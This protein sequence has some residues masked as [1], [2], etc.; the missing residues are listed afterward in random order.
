MCGN[1]NNYKKISVCLIK[2]FFQRKALAQVSFLNEM[3]YLFFFIFFY[4]IFFFQEFR[5][6]RDKLVS[7]LEAILKKKDAEIR[8]YKEQ[9]KQLKEKEEQFTQVSNT[10]KFHY[11]E[12]LK[13]RHFVN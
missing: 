9:I 6:E 1:E 5:E 4:F 7:G 12:H 13:L 2:G 10:V 11:Y 3:A 8:Q